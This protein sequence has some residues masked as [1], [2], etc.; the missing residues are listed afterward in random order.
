MQDAVTVMG[1]TARG[2]SA[3]SRSFPSEYLGPCQNKVVDNNPSQRRSWRSTE[4]WPFDGL[5]LD[6]FLPLGLAVR[7][8]STLL[9]IRPS[10][11]NV[12]SLVR[13]EGTRCE[14][15]KV[16]SESLIYR[17]LWLQSPCAVFWDLVSP[18]CDDC[19]SQRTAHVANWSRLG[20]RSVR[21]FLK[22]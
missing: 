16:P 14:D 21:P 1:A 11:L 19:P 17:C 12:D 13:S 15:H 6:E 2:L 22:P 8:I 4:G 3:T 7:I 20:R 10:M 9:R 5:G 18:L